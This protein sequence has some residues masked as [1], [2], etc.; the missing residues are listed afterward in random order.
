MHLKERNQL[1]QLDQIPKKAFAF[2][3]RTSMAQ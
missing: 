3:I 1:H 2:W